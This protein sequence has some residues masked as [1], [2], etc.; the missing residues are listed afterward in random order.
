MK[1]KKQATAATCSQFLEGTTISTTFRF[2]HLG[3]A[4]PADSGRLGEEA[5]TR[6]ARAQGQDTVL[7]HS[8]TEVQKRVFSTMDDC[9]AESTLKQRPF[10]D[11]LDSRFYSILFIRP[12]SCAHNQLFQWRWIRKNLKIWKKSLWNCSPSRTFWVFPVLEVLQLCRM[13]K[14]RGLQF[15]LQGFIPQPL[16]GKMLKTLRVAAVLLCKGI[17]ALFHALLDDPNSQSSRGQVR[18][19]PICHSSPQPFPQRRLQ[20][21][22]LSFCQQQL[23]V[24]ELSQIFP[25]LCHLSILAT[26]PNIWKV[27]ETIRKPLLHQVLNLQ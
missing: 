11:V 16:L 3:Q 5:T 23:L 7:R 4:L 13:S 18:Y 15:L 22:H 25:T 20:L 17:H 19:P 12:R 9:K 6:R 8:E 27:A 2:Q 24:S 21:Q 1:Q 26:S 10:K 14:L